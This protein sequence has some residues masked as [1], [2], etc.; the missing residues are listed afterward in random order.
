MSENLEGDE[1]IRAFAPATVSN[2]GPGFD[3]FGFSIGEPGDEVAARISDKPGVRILSIDGMAGT[4]PL[5]AAR[6]TASVAAGAV[7]EAYPDISAGTGL[8]LVVTKGLP[9]GSGL[10]SSA[11]SAVGGAVAAMGALERFRGLPHDEDLVFEAAMA[12]EMVASGSRH[13]DNVAP[14]LF[15]GFVVVQSVDPLRVARFQP[16]L[17][18]HVS[19]VLPDLY[20]PTKVA[21]EVLPRQVELSGA[22]RN[23]ANASSLVYALLTGD[24][25]LLRHVVEDHLVE[26]HRSKLIPGYEAVKKAALDAGAWAVAITGSGPALFA[27]SPNEAIARAAGDGM[28]GAFEAESIGSTVLVTTISSAGARLL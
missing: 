16:A 1:W 2:V 4:L 17:E 27:L 18:C 19:V 10:G 23:W 6:N 14:S 25:D 3:C 8:E 28:R 5:D 24:G 12:G 22:V 13:G 21:R 26:P 9:A 7:L 15:G 11:A 20:V